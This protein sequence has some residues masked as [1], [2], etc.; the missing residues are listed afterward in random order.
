MTPEI[1]Q[2]IEKMPTVRKQ[3]G[4]KQQQTVNCKYCNQNIKKQDMKDHL[5]SHKTEISQAVAGESVVNLK[6]NKM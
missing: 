4:V 6:M 2:L 5:I 3:E 1:N